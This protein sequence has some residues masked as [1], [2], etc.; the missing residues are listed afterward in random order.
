MLV[1]RSLV[2]FSV[3]ETAFLS[4]KQYTGATEVCYDVG[5][6]TNH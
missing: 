6:F 1:L 3:P 5:K 4:L 2:D